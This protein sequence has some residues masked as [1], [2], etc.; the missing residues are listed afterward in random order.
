M[1][2]LGPYVQKYT[3]NLREKTA[4]EYNAAHSNYRKTGNVF[5][6]VSIGH[7]KT[8]LHELITVE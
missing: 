2:C 8:M 3:D 4:C 6:V 5:D 1:I 7:F